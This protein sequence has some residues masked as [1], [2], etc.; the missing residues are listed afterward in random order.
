MH[1]RT[2]ITAASIFL[3]LAANLAAEEINPI[4][5]RVGDH[6]LR[7]S[8]IDR[9]LANQPAIQKSVQNDPQ[10]RAAL[11]REILTKKIIVA[12]ARKDGFDRK[13]D[14]K[15]QLSYVVDNFLAQEYLIKVVAAGV[16]VPEGEIKK[17]YDDNIKQ[18]L[19]PEQIR[20]RHILI[21]ADNS[22]TPDERLNART[23]AEA[24]LQR[25][26]SGEDFTKIA[27]EISDDSLSS[28]KGGE[29]PVITAGKTNAVEFEKAAFAL[30]NGETS[31]IVESPFGFHI[32]R[33]IEHQE[34]RTARYED[35]RE[36][37]LEQLK[38]AYEQ[39]RIQEYVE[40]AVKDAGM[41]IAGEKTEP[42]PEPAKPAPPQSG[43]PP[44]RRD[45][46]GSGAKAVNLP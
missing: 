4:V 5:G 44:A 23:R 18:F 33:M 17:A 19:L 11:V 9:I 14:V 46:G 7:E 39:K 29:L 41:E 36:L 34:Q 35:V 22:A 40:K 24:A 32:I 45:T 10:Q 8:D 20:V 21:A 28:T 38:A 3:I 6:V 42:P 2:T 15:E 30:K 31:G 13:P 25:V 16:T 37:I 43:E 12:K 27:S 26:R 1:V